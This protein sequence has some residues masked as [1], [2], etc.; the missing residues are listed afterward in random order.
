MIGEHCERE[1]TLHPEQYGSRM[2]R[3][4]VD[5]VGVDDGGAAVLWGREGGGS[6]VYGCG[7]DISKHGT[8]MSNAQDEEHGIGQK[9]SRVDEQLH[10]R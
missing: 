7:S 9:P 1:G 4:A 3:S 2:R 10:D 6:F 8:G 5:A